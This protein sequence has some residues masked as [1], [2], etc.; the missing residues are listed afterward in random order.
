MVMVSILRH[1][2]LAAGTGYRCLLLLAPLVLIG[3]PLACGVAIGVAGFAVGQPPVEYA[4]GFVLEVSATLPGATLS[5]AAIA[6]VLGSTAGFA[7]CC[8]GWSRT[9]SG[10]TE[11]VIR[12]VS[13]C[14]AALFNLRVPGFE[15]PRPAI[16]AFSDP[17]L[18]SPRLRAAPT[19]AGLSG[20]LP[21]LN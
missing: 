7:L 20:A 15:V 3:I 5:V 21:L 10:L 2:D 18:S 6:I 12:A 4:S 11:T 14:C 8:A 9:R 13:R 19:A 1:T 16:I 17:M